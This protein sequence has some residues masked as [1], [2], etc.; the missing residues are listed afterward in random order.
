[1]IFWNSQ[2]LIDKACLTTKILPISQ[3]QKVLKSQK[4]KNM[5]CKFDLNDF[6]TKRV[7]VRQQSANGRLREAASILTELLRVRPCHKYDFKIRD[8]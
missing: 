6:W 1:L 3:K 8:L 2:E 7:S 4:F 5:L